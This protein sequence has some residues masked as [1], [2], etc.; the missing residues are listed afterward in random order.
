[1]DWIRSPEVSDSI[2]GIS[3]WNPSR[4]ISKHQK[5]VDD[6]EVG[7][8][9]QE[10][11]VFRLSPKV[12]EPIEESLLIALAAEVWNVVRILAAFVKPVAWKWWQD[13][14]F[15]LRLEREKRSAY[16]EGLKKHLLSSHRHFAV[17]VV[18]AI[19]VA[20][21]SHITFFGES[22]KGGAIQ[23]EEDYQAPGWVVKRKYRKECIVI[24]NRV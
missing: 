16:L 10:E 21:G 24:K 15:D 3:W 19:H 13:Q 11:E 22:K 2:N 6:T 7:D 12:G 4:G 20:R 5:G 18:V 17:Q 14:L 1:V 23:V 9:M 8:V